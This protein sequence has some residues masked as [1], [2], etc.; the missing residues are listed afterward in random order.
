MSG[1]FLDTRKIAVSQVSYV[2]TFLVLTFQRDD[3]KCMKMDR[4]MCYGSA[5]SR[6]NG[7]GR[8]KERVKEGKGKGRGESCGK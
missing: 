1:V 3:N 4:D 2:L 5:V 6:R 7:G 8:R